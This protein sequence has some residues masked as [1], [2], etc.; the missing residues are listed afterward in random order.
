MKMGDIESKLSY[1]NFPYLS[2]HRSYLLKHYHF[3][4]K[5]FG[6]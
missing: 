6:N 2:S 4:N 3:L 1:D 5:A